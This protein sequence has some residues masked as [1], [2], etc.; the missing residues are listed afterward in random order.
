MWINKHWLVVLGKFWSIF[1]RYLIMYVSLS[2]FMQIFESLRKIS[3][4][5]EFPDFDKII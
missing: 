2:G 1:L 3:D 5:K 4:F